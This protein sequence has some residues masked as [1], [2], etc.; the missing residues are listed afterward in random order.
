MISGR[1][2]MSA[3]STS[4]STSCSQEDGGDPSGCCKSSEEGES[5]LKKRMQQFGSSGVHANSTIST[6]ERSQ[7]QSLPLNGTRRVTVQFGRMKIVVPWKES[8]QTVGELAE[9]ALVRYKKAK[10]LTSSDR[11]RVHR[12]ECASDGG[13]LDMDD[14]LEEVF[15]LNYDQ[16]LAITDEANG[17]SSTPTYSTIQKH[18]QHHYAQP[19]P[20]S[21][22]LEG[23]TTP[24]ASAF[25]SVTVNNHRAASPYTVG[26]ARATSRDLPYP[27]PTKERRDS[28][29]EVSNFDNLP[30]SGLRVSV[31]TPK[32]DARKLNEPI[33]RSSLRTETA[34]RV[35]DATPTKQ[36]RVTLSPEVEKKLAEQEGN[37]RRSERKKHFEKNPGR[38]NRGS[39]RKSRITDA[40]LDAR[41]RIAD[42]LESQSDEKKS[43]STRGRIDQG[44]L[45][46]TTLITFLPAGEKDS[47][48]SKQLGIEVNA[49]FDET[50]DMQSTSEPT[51]LSSI[52]VM[53]IEEGG[54][55]GKDGRIRVGDCIIAIDGKLVDQMSIIRARA[56]ISELASL[57]RPFTLLI[58][59]S[60]ESFLDQESAKPI[61]SA[62]QQAN[63]Q[64]I[65]HTTIVELI[66]SSNGFGFTVTG[67]E[68][69][70]GE[71]LFYI[72]TV[73]PYGVALGHLKSGDRL[74][75]I[76]GTPTGQFTQPEI[77]EKLKETMVGAKIKFLVS[78]VSQSSSI[79]STSSE[80]K[81]NEETTK[82]DDEK[83]S[84]QKL[85]LPALMTPPV[86]KD[87]PTISQ[88]S[89]S[90]FEIIIPFING[91]S[92]AGLGVSLKARVSKKSNGTKIDC[93]I[94]IKNVMHGGAAFK[95]GGLR[96]DDRIIGVED[97]DLEQ[98]DN[99]E[100]QAALAKKLKEVGMVSSNVRLSIVRN[101]EYGPGQISRDL[102]RI[103][104]D[105]SS[106][107]PSSRMSSHTAPDSLLQSPNTRATSSS[108]ADSSHSRQSSSSSA[109]PAPVRPN[110]RDSMISDSINRHD[111][112]ELPDSDP[113]NREAPGRKSLSE[114]RGMG[115]AA[116][117]QHI[118][119]F[120]DIKHQRQNSAPTS[121][122]QKRSKSQPRSLSQRN[123]RSPMKLID[124]PQPPV[125]STAAQL[126]TTL[127]DSDMLNRRSQSMESINRPVESILRG[128]G[129]I[130]PG[131]SAAKV[132]FMQKS[133]PD[134]HPFPPGSALL[135]LKS[136][137][138]R[139][140]DKSRR[141]SMGNPFS[142]M[143]N[144]F[145]F[146]SKSREGSPEKSPVE[147]RS[148]ERPK[149]IMDERSGR[150]QRNTAVPP[151][152]PPHQDL[153]RGSAGNVFVDY[154]E[155]YGLIPQYPHNTSQ[156]MASTAPDNVRLISYTKNPSPPPAVST[157][158]LGNSKFYSSYREPSITQRSRLPDMSRTPTLNSTT[159][160]RPIAII[161]VGESTKTNTSSG[162]KAAL[163]STHRPMSTMDYQHLMRTMS[164]PEYHQKPAEVFQKQ[165]YIVSTP[166]NMMKTTNTFHKDPGTNKAAAA[167]IPTTTT[168]ST[169]GSRTPAAAQSVPHLSSSR[170]TDHRR[171]GSQPQ[172]P[173]KE[174]KPSLSSP[175]V[176][177]RRPRP[178][179]VVEGA[180]RVEP[181]PHQQLDHPVLIPRRRSMRM[182]DLENS[183]VARPD[184]L[185]LGTAVDSVRQHSQPT[186]VVT[187]DTRRVEDPVRRAN[188]G[189][190]TR[191]RLIVFPSTRFPIAASSMRVSS[192]A[193]PLVNSVNLRSVSNNKINDSNLANE[194][195]SLRARKKLHREA[196][197]RSEFFLPSYSNEN[198]KLFNSLL[199]PSTSSIMKTTPSPTTNDSVT[200]RKL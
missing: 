155:P 152:P 81:E 196:V 95:E 115:A 4:S 21:R 96:V 162:N 62:L 136:E 192:A 133:S 9:A 24:V 143:R 92:S 87:Y 157:V 20:Y 147:L 15:D 189:G 129:Q 197:T 104:V 188:T 108:G 88:S 46:G 84:T 31:S 50:P 63:T 174:A 44:P 65:G 167:G 5:T 172:P 59:R 36:S 163:R 77:V 102:S 166:S 64:Y 71:R 159:D 101:N 58:N 200:P 32:S 53:K 135:R 98:L 16:I 45:P 85:P 43:Q 126:Q 72:G 114:K 82:T 40:L 132:Q 14:V 103:T 175:V 33:L 94:F 1:L 119:L 3:S 69:S 124:L 37:E 105:A 144:F 34:N 89:Q 142:A 7:Y 8:D 68:T 73:K 141:K 107:S 158:H 51:K 18:Q 199:P 100:A 149:S 49:V 183:T 38:F 80:N 171:S 120:Q 93:G 139:S 70:K 164:M 154:G 75:E 127:D 2:L 123:Y 137:E 91:S 150:D 55:V 182:L 145:G 173:S 17:G 117:P 130:N 160:M 181:L 12:L 22:N 156:I 190:E 29:V 187:K 110:E 122:T 170:P 54:R 28:V 41:D 39:D 112:S 66:K 198:I 116:D 180:L 35:E 67:R 79:P 86:P 61:Q 161:R 179:T 121:S 13:I 169:P 131:G 48:I 140:R 165:R 78:R 19:L 60:L 109:V 97:I 10:G 153:R 148:V 47:E 191:D 74:L 176:A 30:Q 118:K 168:C 194:R 83:A 185:Y 195:I 193:K 26:F 186:S 138:S 11:I 27:P 23:P 111:E 113:F 90:R 56:S 125:S 25:G 52:Q 76:N 146:G 178:L 106:P 42:Q 128:T 151:P 134:Q 184:S 177:V 57:N 99:R 6:L